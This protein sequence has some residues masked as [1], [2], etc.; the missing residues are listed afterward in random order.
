MFLGTSKEPL[1]LHS[2]TPVVNVHQ[3]PVGHALGEILLGHGGAL[4]RQTGDDAGG[5]QQFLQSLRP[6]GV[7]QDGHLPDNAAEEIGES[8][9]TGAVLEGLVGAVQLGNGLLQQ[10]GPEAIRG[11]WLHEGQSTI[12]GGQSIVDQ[13]LHPLAAPPQP[14]AKDSVGTG[15]G[16]IGGHHP[17]EQIPQGAEQPQAGDQPAITHFTRHHIEFG[18]LVE[19]HRWRYRYRYR[20]GYSSRAIVGQIH[21]TFPLEGERRRLVIEDGRLNSGE[22]GVFP[23]HVL[24]PAIAQYALVFG[25]HYLGVC[26]VFTSL[27]IPIP[28]SIP[29]PSTALEILIPILIFS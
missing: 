8:I 4:V 12:D 13:N 17:V 2:Y 25:C 28:I 23:Q 9:R 21:D 14:E 24:R 3:Y 20:S 26:I 18:R 29:L 6:D 10:G 27:P 11:L 22:I 15:Q 19:E 5:G 7:R 16:L 1:A